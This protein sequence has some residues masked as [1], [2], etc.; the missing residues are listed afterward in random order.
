MS[1]LSLKSSNVEV[2][3]A[4]TGGYSFELTEAVQADFRA[5]N[6]PSL[7]TSLLLNAEVDVNAHRSSAFIYDV[8]NKSLQLPAG[9]SYTDRGPDL[10]K[11]DAR[12]LTF[13]IPSSGLVWNVMPQDYRGKRLPGGSVGEYMTEAYV[14]G[15]MQE[16]ALAAWDLM[17]ELAMA[18]LIV[19]DQNLT[20]GGPGKQYSFH[21]EIFGSARPGPVYTNL[22]AVSELDHRSLMIKTRRQLQ[23]RL[24][25]AGKSAT[26]GFMVVA[27]DEYFTKRIALEAQTGLARDLRS[28]MDLASQRV[29]EI[30]VGGFN[31]DSFVGIDGI[32]YINYG[33]NIIAGQKL[34]PDA[35]AYM[36]PLGVE[37]MMSIE[38]APAVTRSHVNEEA[39][40]MYMWVEEHERKGVLAEIE[41]NRLYMNRNPEL[42]VELDE[43]PTPP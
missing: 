26:R 2:L 11:D 22:A 3:K 32:T 35:K 24:G 42:I 20:L 1:N 41:S 23:Q 8:V 10:D 14:A 21:Q 4:L 29:P 34:I 13:A 36:I 15:L 39:Q 38:L 9:K 5:V 16:K 7:L 37:N 12:Q 6:T 17:N 28:A 18:K 31:Y 30:N 33:S 43:G 27:G 25:L 40:A 19:D